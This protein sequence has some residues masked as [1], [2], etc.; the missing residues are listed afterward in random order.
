MAA[1][2]I[3]NTYSGLR[4]ATR[5]RFWLVPL[6]ALLGLAAWQLIVVVGQYPAFILPAP[7]RVARRL[8]IALTDGT[9]L[10]H[11]AITL[12]E[13]LL[14]LVLGLLVASLL[15]YLLAK[16]PAV[17]RIVAP[18]VVASQSVP[19]VAYAPLLII[20]F[21]SGLLSKV[22]ICT[23]IVFFPILINVVVGMRG[24]P[25]ELRD[26]MRSLR[27]SP[28]QTFLH[29]ELPAALPVL[30]GG[31]KIGATLSV[32]GAVV[33]EFMGADA[34]LGF[35]VIL[36]RGQFDTA[37]IFVA[38]FT[39]VAIAMSIYSVIALLERRLLKWHRRY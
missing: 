39:L 2:D 6:S 26:L 37:L 1:L 22:L 5:S 4:G 31:L 27:A 30:L 25:E 33:G 15:G 38:I 28:W 29:L 32:I 36:G 17:E 14:G 10:R 19:V 12:G 21:G 16:S 20:W 34:G 35:L 8:S 13:V 18:Y 11:T 24:V 7:A 9:L 23:L 3:S